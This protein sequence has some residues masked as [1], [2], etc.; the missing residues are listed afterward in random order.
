MAAPLATGQF[1]VRICRCEHIGGAYIWGLVIFD[2]PYDDDYE[3]PD[4]CTAVEAACLWIYDHAGT[5]PMA[6]P[7]TSVLSIVRVLG[8]P[9]QGGQTDDVGA[10]AP[11][12]ALTKP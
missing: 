9:V 4:S 2:H 6:K 12:Q 1:D 11:P 7:L 3:R 8:L 5:Q 10:P